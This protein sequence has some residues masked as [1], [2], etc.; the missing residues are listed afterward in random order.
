MN[1]LTSEHSKI[2]WKSISL[3]KAI[4]MLRCILNY[5]PSRLSDYDT[6]LMV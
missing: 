4:F 6:L 3:A 1:I 5:E 2:N